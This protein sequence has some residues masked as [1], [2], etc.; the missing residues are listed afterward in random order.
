MTKVAVWDEQLYFAS[1]IGKVALKAYEPDFCVS[2]RLTEAW[3]LPSVVPDAV[4]VPTT[5]VTF[6]PVTGWPYS[7]TSVAVKATVFDGLDASAPVYAS[8]V[9]RCVT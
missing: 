6:L 9:S 8:V 4:C 2:F 7:S 5:N 1:P 3:P